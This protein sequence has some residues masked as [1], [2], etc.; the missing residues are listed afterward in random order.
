MV[1]SLIVKIFYKINQDVLWESNLT[2]FTYNFERKI[3]SI[4]VARAAAAAGLAALAE[5]PAPSKPG[6]IPATAYRHPQY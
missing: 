3:A 2:D 4:T 5:L 6:P 1:R